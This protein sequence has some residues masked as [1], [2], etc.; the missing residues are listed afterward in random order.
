MCGVPF[1]AADG[2]IAQARE[3]G[4][5]GRHLRAGGGPARRPRGWCKR[6]VVRVVSPGTLTDGTYLDAREPSVPDGDRAA[7][8]RAAAGRAAGATSFGVALRRSLD[9][10]VSRRRIR[11]RQRHAGAGRRAERPAAAR[12]AGPARHAGGRGVSRDR[13]ARLH[14]DR[15]GR[16]GVRRPTP[17]SARC[18]EQLRVQS[19]DGFGMRDRVGRHARRGRPA[20]APARLAE[21]GPR[22]RAVAGVPDLGRRAAHRR[23]D[24][25]PPGADRRQRRAA[26]RARCS[27]RS[28]APSSAMGGRLLRAWLL[29]PLVELER[30]RERLDA[31]EELAFR[32]RRARAAARGAGVA[33][34]SR[35]AARPRGAR[36]RRAARFRR[37]RATRARVIPAGRPDPRRRRGAAGPEPVRR[38][39]RPGRRAARASSARCSTIR[40]RWR[41]RAASRATASIRRST[42]C[43]PSAGP[44]GRSSP[45]WKTAERERT[46]IALA[47][48]ALQPRVRLLHRDLEVEPAPGPGRLRAQADDCRRRALHH[49]GAAGLRGEGPRRRRADPGARAGGLRG[50][51][52]RGRGRGATHPGQRARPGHAGRAGGAGRDRRGAQ[53]HQAARPRRRRAGGGRRAPSGGRGARGGRLRARTTST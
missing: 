8:P 28:T 42:S 19:L 43:A 1:H 16:G 48:G 51:D 7:A 46:G 22:P 45:T 26:R 33:A 30:I 17:P 47:Q 24:L 20:A 5:P 6:E 35:A 15:G 37:A 11:R 9:R 53:L 25:P 13:R 21:G 29:R 31:V 23:R 34:R 39:G 14:R 4:V 50:A 38:A 40:R 49:A 41:A 2:Y 12:D 10:R 3:Q 18:C 32:T 52:A 36:H 27:T 44:A